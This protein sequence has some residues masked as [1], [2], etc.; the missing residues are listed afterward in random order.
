M[1][2]ESSE[3]WK[4]VVEF[5]NYEISNMGRLRKTKTQRILKPSL[6][7]SGYLKAILTKEKV[8]STKFIHRL[9]ADA[10]IPNP[11]SNQEV[12]HIVNDKTNNR[13]S[14]LRWSTRKE[15]CN[16]KNGNHKK[17]AIIQIQKNGEIVEHE[18]FTGLQK[19]GFVLSC[20]RRCLNYPESTYRDCHWKKKKEYTEEKMDDEEWVKTDDSVYEK[21]K[22]YPGYEV[23]NMG[24]VRGKM[25][26]I[27]KYTEY[28]NDVHKVNLTNKFKNKLFTVHSL[29]IMAFNIP[30]PE[31][32]TEID[33]IDGNF[34]NNHLSNLRWT[35]GSENVNNPNTK[36]PGVKKS[37]E[38]RK[39]QIV[40]IKDG[41]EMRF[42]GINEAGKSLGMH[43]RTIRKHI[44]SGESYK[45]YLFT[46][47]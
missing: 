14:S 20:V 18:S 34:R 9:V 13:A 22:N 11:E 12:Q 29:V 3:E 15:I 2:A 5:E 46:D 26:R 4:P 33:H 36:N 24:R 44:T 10:F 43:P 19:K 45:D 47:K 31:S 6:T 40:A 35:S 8:S 41:E 7:R 17:E 39:R 32:K 16:K 25:G 27:L 37:C 23:S 30:N 28:E 42:N 1:S 21:V 38:R